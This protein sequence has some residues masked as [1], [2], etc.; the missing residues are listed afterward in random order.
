MGCVGSRAG[1]RGWPKC[2]VGIS[3]IDGA[4]FVLSSAAWDDAWA[5]AGA[6]TG[7]P[8]LGQKRACATSAVPQC[9]QFIGSSSLLPVRFRSFFGPL[10][11]ISLL[12]ACVQ[13]GFH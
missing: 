2:C 10:Y 6:A 12:L 3:D 9:V 1:A 7:V 13:A 11:S 4:V 8:Q 5:G